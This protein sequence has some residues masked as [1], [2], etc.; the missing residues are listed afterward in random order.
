MQEANRQSPGAVQG[1]PRNWYLA[2]TNN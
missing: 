1:A 2:N